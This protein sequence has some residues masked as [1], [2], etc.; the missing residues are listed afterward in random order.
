MKFY[1]ILIS[2]LISGSLTVKIPFGQNSGINNSLAS[3][4]NPMYFQFVRR[5]PY[6]QNVHSAEFGSRAD[7]NSHE[8]ILRRKFCSRFRR[9]HCDL[10]KFEHYYHAFL[11][12]SLNS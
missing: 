6:S 9:G 3:K 5:S 1:F 11:V 7:Y 4:G 2:G 10:L 8:A 12:R